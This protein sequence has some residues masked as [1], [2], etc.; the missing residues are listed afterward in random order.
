[1]IENSNTRAP[2]YPAYAFKRSPTWFKWVKLTSADIHALRVE[3]GFEGQNLYFHLNHPIRYVVLVA[4]VVSIEGIFDRYVLLTIDDGSGSTIVVKIKRLATNI[5]A[6][7]DCP[8]NTSVSN[9][10]VRA[11]L[12]FFNVQIDDTTLDIGTVVKVKC[13]IEEFR[14]VKQLDLQ[15]TS[16]VKTTAE[17][18]KAWSG[19]SHFNK[20]VLSSPWVLTNEELEILQQE[21][22]TE[23]DDLRKAE[24][25]QGTSKATQ[26]ATE[27]ERGN[28]EGARGKA[29]DKETQPGGTDE[30]GSSNLSFRI[31]SM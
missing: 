19:L 8:S 10:N 27:R 13:T 9:V 18:I 12:G 7:I 23:K 29:R 21:I 17:E 5:S 31:P 25:A 22:V 28:V 2:I 20:T 14:G 6:A 1:M 3:P 15:R 30:C 4:P 16:V 26:G 11:G 24:V